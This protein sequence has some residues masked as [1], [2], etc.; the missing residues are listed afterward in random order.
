[1]PTPEFYRSEA[2]RLRSEVSKA[3]GAEVSRLLRLAAEYD[4][5]ADSLGGVRQEKPKP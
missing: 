2:D 3:K 1:M 5:I 4:Q